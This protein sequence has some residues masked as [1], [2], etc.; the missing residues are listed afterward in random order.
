MPH[1]NIQVFLF[2]SYINLDDIL[3]SQPRI[4]RMMGLPD[5]SYV[6]RRWGG[7]VANLPLEISLPVM[8]RWSSTSVCSPWQELGRI[9]EERGYLLFYERGLG[10]NM[11]ITGTERIM[12]R[13]DMRSAINA[14]KARWNI[15]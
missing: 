6:Q 2:P 13:D 3:V 7:T 15:R 11:I 5:E 8:V 14:F 4:F 9:C 12:N 10:D 1:A